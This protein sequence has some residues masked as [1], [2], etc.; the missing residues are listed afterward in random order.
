MANARACTAFANDEA[1]NFPQVNLAIQ[2]GKVEIRTM[3]FRVPILRVAATFAV[4]TLVSSETRAQAPSDAELKSLRKLLEQQARQLDW[5]SAQVAK[6]SAK[7]EGTPPPPARAAAAP[8]AK[9]ASGDSNGEFVVPPARVVAAPAPP[10]NIHVVVKGESL[11][12]IATDK[13]TTMA[14]LLKLNRIRDPKKI[15]IGQRLILPPTPAA[16]ATPAAA[17]V[18]PTPPSPQPQK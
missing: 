18:P 6:L 3:I 8:A 1:M 10:Q 11:G 9:P 14:E 16:P 7:I 13:G 2:L 5:L 17:P 15:Q 12:K 4:A